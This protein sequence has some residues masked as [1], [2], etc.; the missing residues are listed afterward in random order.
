[1]ET[2]LKHSLLLTHGTTYG[3]IPT[4]LQGK[5]CTDRFPALYRMADQV[6]WRSGLYPSEVASSCFVGSMTDNAPIDFHSWSVIGN[7]GETGMEWWQQCMTLF[8]RHI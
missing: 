1:M 7:I 4:V 2:A 5:D 8:M 6:E 3:Y